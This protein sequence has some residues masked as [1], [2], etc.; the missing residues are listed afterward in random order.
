[1]SSAQEQFRLSSTPIQ[2]CAHMPTPCALLP[3]E[4]VLPVV[5]LACRKGWQRKR[6]DRDPCRM[7]NAD[8][9]QFR[10]VWQKISLPFHFPDSIQLFAIPTYLFSHLVANHSPAL[11]RSSSPPSHQLAL[12]AH[13]LTSWQEQICCLVW[14]SL[15]Q[16]SQAISAPPTL[17]KG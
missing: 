13:L 8:V 1:M 6:G 2:V 9:W 7:K 12:L 17:A 3:T 10:A 4:L 15:S 5:L 11:G 14:S 16:P